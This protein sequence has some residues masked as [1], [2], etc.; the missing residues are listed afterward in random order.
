MLPSTSV[1]LISG[2]IHK[3]FLLRL[4]LVVHWPD[5]P[6]VKRLLHPFHD[7]QEVIVLYDGEEDT[8]DSSKKLALEMPKERPAFFSKNLLQKTNPQAGRGGDGNHP[9]P[10]NL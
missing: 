10:A 2:V 7:F 4:E 3:M 6:Q 5:S 9:R 1:L 8:F